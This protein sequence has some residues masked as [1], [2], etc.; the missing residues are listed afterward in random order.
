MKEIA[1]EDHTRSIEFSFHQTEVQS[2]AVLSWDTHPFISAMDVETEFLTL[3]NPLSQDISLA[4]YQLIDSKHIH[5]LKFNDTAVIPA[6]GMLYVYTCPGGNHQ[7]RFLEPNV[8]WTNHDGS[9]RKKEILH[10]THCTMLLYDAN[11]RMISSITHNKDQSPVIRRYL[12]GKPLPAS[13]FNDVKEVAAPSTPS[14]TSLYLRLTLATVRLPLLA[15]M[16]YSFLFRSHYALAFYWLAFMVD[17]LS[18]PTSA[19]ASPLSEQST[20]STSFTVEQSLAERIL[21]L[22]IMGDRINVAILY[23]ATLLAIT[24]VSNDVIAFVFYVVP[25]LLEVG[26]LSLHHHQQH[27]NNHHRKHSSSSSLSSVL[28]YDLLRGKHR[29]LVTAVGLGSELFLLLIWETITWQSWKALNWNLT[30]H[31]SEETSLWQVLHWSYVLAILSTAFAFCLR[32]VNNGMRIHRNLFLSTSSEKEV[33]DISEDNEKDGSDD[34]D[35]V[36][37]RSGRHHHTTPSRPSRTSTPHFARSRS[38][39]N[40]N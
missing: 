6:N 3:V 28:L 13:L 15:A 12:R 29:L 26:S 17:I 5:V 37:V 21:Q 14:L 33:I 34:N 10:N 1:I 22:G 18:R 7:T 4:N 27:H 40:E 19:N 9:L 36:S 32:Q 25:V 39:E 16:G 2:D 8:L 20:S 38:L 35:S 30:H 31:L 24:T 23:L 11:D